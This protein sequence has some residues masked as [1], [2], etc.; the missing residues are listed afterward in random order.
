MRTKTLFAAAA[1]VAAGIASSMAQ[2]VYSLNVVGYVNQ[3]IPSGY[4]LIA[5]P[6]SAGVSNGV[7]EVMVPP[8]ACIVQS[9]NGISYD[10]RTLD[11]SDWL[12]LPSFAPSSPPTVT[13]GNGFF[14]YNPGAAYTNTWVG[15]VRPAP[16]TTNTMSMPSGYSLVGSVM[17]VAGANI[18]A[19]PVGLPTPDG[20]IV[21]TFNG[22][23]YDQ[24]TL[25]GSDWLS[26]PSFA[27]TT[28]PGHVVGRGFFFFNPGSAVNWNQTLP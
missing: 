28:A 4:S 27:I 16:G 8:D 11:G 6:L 25:D 23:A 2:S 20:C 9:F 12:S 17:P 5:N 22:V 10:T 3:V 13:P 21:S 15:E 7:N 14:F 24:R 18:G 19:A 1:I 26:L